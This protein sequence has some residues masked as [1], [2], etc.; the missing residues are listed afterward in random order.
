MYP[1]KHS[2]RERTAAMGLGAEGG[3]PGKKE[4][5]DKEAH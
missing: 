1:L 3:N 4:R 2:F 5:E